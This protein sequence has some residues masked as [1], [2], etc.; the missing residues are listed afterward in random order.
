MNNLILKWK[1]HCDDGEIVAWF[2]RGISPDGSYY[3]EVVRHEERRV[4]TVEGQLSTDDVKAIARIRTRF[5]FN[6]EAPPIPYESFDG[7]LAMGEVSR[8]QVV[9]VYSQGAEENPDR[10]SFLE[11]IEIL[12]PYLY[13]R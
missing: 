8:P 7:L 9:Y 10:D 1:E 11:L 3:G 13:E 4:L 5:S 12:R 6:A 2:I